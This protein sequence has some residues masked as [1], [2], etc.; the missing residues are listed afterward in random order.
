MRAASARVLRLVN[1]LQPLRCAVRSWGIRPRVPKHRQ[2]PRIARLVQAKDIE[3]PVA[4]FDFEVAVA[5]SRPPI[6]V[7]DDF[8]TAPIQVQALRVP[9]TVAIDRY[10]HAIHPARLDVA[11]H[12]AQNTTIIAHLLAPV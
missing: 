12:I 8:D 4:A 10:L 3:I 2:F 7:L 9:D 6:D 1:L 11:P 5:R